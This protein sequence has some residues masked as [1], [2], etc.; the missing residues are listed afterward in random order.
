MEGKYI[1]LEKV[2]HITYIPIIVRAREKKD[3]RD[4][5][6]KHYVVE[7]NDDKINSTHST[8]ECQIMK[9]LFCTSNRTDAYNINYYCTVK[10]Y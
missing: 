6:I 8:G 10:F 4:G 3:K 9:N 1:S 2:N 5:R 7:I